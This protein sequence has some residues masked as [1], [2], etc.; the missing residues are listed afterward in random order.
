M[1]YSLHFGI[2]QVG[3]PL[4]LSTEN[5]KNLCFLIDTGSTHDVIFDFVYQH[6]QDSFTLTSENQDMMG[7][8]GSFKPTQIINASIQFEDLTYNASFVVLEANDA[9]GQ[10]QKETGV[11]IHGI[12]G[13]PFLV[14]NKC[15]LD[16]DEL[17][18]KGFSNYNN[19]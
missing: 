16:F 18:L 1:R 12:L 19:R 2:E 11:Q 17:T 8:E 14:E 15:Q 10:V 3:L 13:I 7:I 9:I 4:I 6:F 5:P